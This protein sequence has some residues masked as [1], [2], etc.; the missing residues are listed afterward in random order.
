MDAED[1]K[2]ID[3]FAKGVVLNENAALHAERRSIST[4]G[5]NSLSSI[6]RSISTREELFR[7]NHIQENE[8]IFQKPAPIGTSFSQSSLVSFKSLNMKSSLTSTRPHNQRKRGGTHQSFSVSRHQLRRTVI[9]DTTEQIKKR[10]RPGSI[11][12]LKTQN[13]SMRSSYGSM[14]FDHVSTSLPRSSAST[15]NVSFDKVSIRE[16]PR[17][18]GDNP[19]VKTGPPLS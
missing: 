13:E 14:N 8:R 5:M 19:S 9:N 12:V 3:R 16:Y 6:T 2:I 10:K 17:C 4:T 18:V 7:P 1:R 11:L 15:T